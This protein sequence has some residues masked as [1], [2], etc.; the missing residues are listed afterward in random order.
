MATTKEDFVEA[1]RM[2]GIPHRMIAG[3]PHYVFDRIRPGGFAVSLL[4]NDLTGACQ[5]AD[6]ENARLLQDYVSFLVEHAPAICWGSKARVEAWLNN[7]G[8]TQ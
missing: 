7:K 1:A 8:E 6:D 4:E 2:A 5:S 3:L